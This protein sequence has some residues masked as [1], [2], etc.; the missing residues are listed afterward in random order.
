[1]RCRTCGVAPHSADTAASPGPSRTVAPTGVP[2]CGRH[3]VGSTAIRRPPHTLAAAAVACLVTGYR[4]REI[5]HEP[6]HWVAMGLAYALAFLGFFVLFELFV[7]VNTNTWPLAVLFGI[8]GLPVVFDVLG[9]LLPGLLDL[10]YS[11]VGVALFAVGTFVFYFDRLQFVRVAGE[12][13]DPVIVI[14]DAGQVRD[15]NRRAAEVFP[16]L[17]DSIGVDIAERLPGLAAVL[18]N[19]DASLEREID[20]ENR[21]FNVSV[22]AF[23][24]GGARTGR[25]IVLSD[26][27]ARE[28]YRRELETKNQ[29]LEQFASIVSHDLRNPLQVATGR[30]E[31]AIETGEIEHLEPVVR[32]HDR[33]EQLIDEMLTLAREGVSIDET[34][35]VDIGNL[36]RQSWG[37]VET[38]AASLVVAEGSRAPSTPTRASSTALREPLPE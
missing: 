28:R 17:S 6:I 13:D 19:P 14:N 23:T 29:K 9:A 18:D 35:S 25:S 31:L 22:S 7:R 33:M 1:M 5:T 16:S 32:A 38:D 37:M 34:G 26:V 15:Y 27:T 10:T 20:G 24:A 3:T 21:Y 8:T 30:T 12:T 36:A 4:A 2:M 11:A